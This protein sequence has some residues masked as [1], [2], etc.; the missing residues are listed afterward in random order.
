MVSKKGIFVV[1][2]VLSFGTTSAFA[3]APTNVK[4][5]GTDQSVSY[6]ITNGQVTD[7]IPH[8]QSNSLII[9]ASGTGSSTLTL[10]LPRDVIDTK[11]GGKDSAFAITDDGLPVT[12]Q[13]SK[14]DT[15]RTITI[16]FD[17]RTNPE[18]F[19][20]TGTHVVPEF[21]TITSVILV[22]SIMTIILVTA[23]TKLR[24]MQKY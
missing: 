6:T 22:M 14:T 5:F 10:T 18:I 8:A 23:R 4:V 15:A 21:G 7:V 11:M 1:I 13:E 19:M 12:F 17:Y 2:M 24:F 9:F 3:Q 16:S 20:I